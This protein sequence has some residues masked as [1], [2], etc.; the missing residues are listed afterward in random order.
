MQQHHVIL[1]LTYT[2]YSEPKMCLQCSFI[3]FSHLS[4]SQI[5]QLS[6]NIA[7]DIDKQLAAKTKELLG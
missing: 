2:N 1:Y 4:P 6:D 5:Q 3:F 7:A